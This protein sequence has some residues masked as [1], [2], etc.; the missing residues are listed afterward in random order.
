[1]S[2]IRAWGTRRERK[3]TKLWKVLKVQAPGFSRARR[4]FLKT[5]G[6][7]DT[8][9]H[10]LCAAICLPWREENEELISCLGFPF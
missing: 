5:G 4:N 7:E 6:G 1:M 8:P 2:E 10:S 9:V 3:T